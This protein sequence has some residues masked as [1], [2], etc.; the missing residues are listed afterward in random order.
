[1]KFTLQCHYLYNTN[2]ICEFLHKTISKGTAQ[3]FSDYTLWMAAPWMSILCPPTHPRYPAPRTA[4][5]P[6]T[7]AQ[8]TIEQESQKG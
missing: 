4:K 5:A 8:F 7:A 6:Q 3:A 2:I 1:M